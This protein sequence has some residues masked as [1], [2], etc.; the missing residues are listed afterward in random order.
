MAKRAYNIG[1]QGGHTKSTALAVGDDLHILG[2]AHGESLNLHTYPPHEVLRRLEHLLEKLASEANMSLTELLNSTAKTALAMPGAGAEDDLALIKVCLVRPIWKEESRCLIL[3]DTWAGL[4]AGAF[5]SRGTCAF[6][7]TGASIYV[8]DKVEK[9]VKFYGKPHKINGWGPL[10]G[11]FGSGFQLATYMFRFF[12]RELDTKGTSEL[13]DKLIEIEP[14]IKVI[15]NAQRWFDALCIMNPH[16]WRI[17]FAKLARAVTSSADAATPDLHAMTLVKT[18]ANEITDSIGI[19]LQR[20]PGARNLPVVLQGGMFEH[21]K[22]YRKLVI[23]TF[24]PQITNN[25]YLA[26]FRPVIGALLLA[27]VD[28]KRPLEQSLDMSVIKELYRN[29][30]ALPEGKQQ[31]LTRVDGYAPFISEE[32]ADV[33]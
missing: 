30:Q 5:L 28:M 17:K 4:V 1:V 7:G 21:S 9:E 26:F 22:L 6:A 31:L 15:S 18:V 13:F 27:L 10:I 33:R 2:V 32:K 11:D 12:G 19:A 20:F 14:R 23:E 25:I 29:V 16:D 3:D 8:N 24:K